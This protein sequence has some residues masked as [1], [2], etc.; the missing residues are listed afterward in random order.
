MS[1]VSGQI[2]KSSSVLANCCFFCSESEMLGFN[3]IWVKYGETQM[4]G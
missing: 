4:L 2:S 3:Q 1:N